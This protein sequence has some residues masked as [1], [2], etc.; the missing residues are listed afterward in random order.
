MRDACGIRQLG[1]WRWGARGGPSGFFRR[2]VTRVQQER[3]RHSAH[4]CGSDSATPRRQGSEHSCAAVVRLGAG[5]SSTGCG[6]QAG[7]EALVHAARLYLQRMDASRAFVKLDFANAFN[8]IRCDAVLEAVAKHRPDLLDF[9]AS[10]YGAS[11][12]LWL[13]DDQQI[14]SAEGVQQGDPLGPLLF[15]L[16]MDKPLKKAQSEFV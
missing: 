4:C 15:C 5:A 12:L 8:S 10:A 13:G 11:T 16:A 6:G 14:S 2:V 9:V 1:P 7:A 3:R